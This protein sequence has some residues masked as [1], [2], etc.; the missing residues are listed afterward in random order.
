MPEHSILCIQKVVEHLNTSTAEQEILHQKIALFQ[1]NFKNAKLIYSRSP[2]QSIIIGGNEKTKEIATT[3][4]QA[5]FDIRPI[6][7]PTVA[8]GSERIR[9]CLHTYNADEDIIAL[10]KKLTE[11]L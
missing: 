2:I 9:V 8:E 10:C 6:L 1:K 5:G 11:L 7:H 3:L 4:Q